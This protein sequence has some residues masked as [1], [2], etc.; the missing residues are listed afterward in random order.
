MLLKEL[1]KTLEKMNCIEQTIE[2][3]GGI[4]DYK[5]DNNFNLTY[6]LKSMIPYLKEKTIF[7]FMQDGRRGMWCNKVYD[8]ENNI[9]LIQLM[10]N[11]EGDDNVFNFI[12]NKGY[13]ISNIDYELVANHMDEDEFKDFI[14]SLENI[15]YETHC[16]SEFCTQVVNNWFK[17]RNE[18]IAEKELIK[19]LINPDFKSITCW[20]RV[21]SK[22]DSC[23]Y[24]H[25]EETN[26]NHLFYS[27]NNTLEKPTPKI[28]VEN[29]MQK[30]WK[31]MNWKY[32]LAKLDTK[33]NKI[34]KES[35]LV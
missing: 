15:D 17:L 28:I 33:S 8:N 27:V 7:N 32:T 2:T 25:F 9:V 10:F 26:D 5:C 3:K 20:Y 23:E 30:S 18:I 11:R 22:D 1:I 14:N 19:K 34:I 4:I 29:S 16:L 24:N 12:L 21:S 31:S 35:D 13:F 6:Q